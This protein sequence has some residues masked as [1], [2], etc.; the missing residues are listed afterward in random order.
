MFRH[1]V[2]RDLKPR[3]NLPDVKGFVEQQSDDAGPG[4]LTKGSERDAA[5]IPLNNRK[6][7]VAGRKTVPLNGL[8]RLAGLCH[9]RVTTKIAQTVVGGKRRDRTP[10]YL[11][12]ST[13]RPPRCRRARFGIVFRIELRLKSL[14]ATLLGGGQGF[15]AEAVGRLRAE[16]VRGN[17]H[18]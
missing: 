10:F 1:V 14:A 5:V 2:G 4:V 15:S 12:Q 7:A 18:D 16:S 17:R 13:S 9:G 6:Y 11:T 8:I 3:R